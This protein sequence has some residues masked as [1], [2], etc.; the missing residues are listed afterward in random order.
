MEFR[1]TAG[2]R[3]TRVIYG[4][5][6]TFS[7]TNYLRAR[8]NER[9]P[10][11][12]FSLSIVYLVVLSTLALSLSLIHCAELMFPTLHGPLAYLYPPVIVADIFR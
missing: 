1:A 12:P 6:L 7:A 3:W 5:E 2:G 8:C 4:A 9:P 10:R 11:N